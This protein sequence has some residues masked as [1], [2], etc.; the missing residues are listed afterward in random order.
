MSQLTA[1]PAWNALKEH[2]DEI[3]DV[4][5][6]DLFANDGERFQKFHR[7]FN[8]S[9][10]FDFSKNRITDKT[11]ALLLNLA[12]QANVSDWARRMFNGDKINITEN[13]AVL[14]IALRNRANRPIIV[15][16]QDVMP[17]VNAVLAHMRAVFRAGALRGV[18][19]LYRQ[20]DHRHR[21]YRHRR[22]RPRPRHGHGSPEALR[23][24]RPQRPFRLQH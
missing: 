4:Q 5:L 17:G 9:L 3:K 16:G 24:A 6:R 20:G 14:H 18:E 23:K 21:Q 8:D 7:T 1:S 2:Y 10:L 13:R 12:E 19:G 11:L 15:D 22:Q